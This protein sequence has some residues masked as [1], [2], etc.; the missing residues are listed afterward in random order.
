MEETELPTLT[1]PS[2]AQSED[3]PWQETE[4]LR[5]EIIVLTRHLMWLPK[6]W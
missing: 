4:A 3:K 1:N 2:S 5:A 6:T